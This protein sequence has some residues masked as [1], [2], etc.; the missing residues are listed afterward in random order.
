MKQIHKL[1]F[2][3]YLQLYIIAIP[4]NLDQL[5][6]TFAIVYKFVNSI[7]KKSPPPK[8]TGVLQPTEVIDPE[9]VC[10]F[11]EQVE[12]ARSEIRAVG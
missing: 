4:N 9:V 8:T 3:L 5:Q 6:Y 11:G 12:I 1:T 7:L 2:N 10:L